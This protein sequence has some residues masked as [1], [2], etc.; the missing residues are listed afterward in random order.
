MKCVSHQAVE[1]RNETRHKQRTFTHIYTKDAKNSITYAL[2]EREREKEKK[3]APL[4]F[5]IDNKCVLNT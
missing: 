2:T 3:Q 1:P 5:K 4:A